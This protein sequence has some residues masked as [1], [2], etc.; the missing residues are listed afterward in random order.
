M[1]RSPPPRTPPRPPDCWERPGARNLAY[2]GAVPGDGW[3][4]LLPGRV[5]SLPCRGRWPLR[6]PRRPRAA[7]GSG[8]PGESGRDAGTYDHL[9]CVHRGRP[10]R[11]LRPR[12]APRRQIL[13]E[14]DATR[15]LEFLVPTAM[16]RSTPGSTTP[17]CSCCRFTNLCCNG[18]SARPQPVPRVGQRRDAGTKGRVMECPSQRIGRR[19]A[20]PYSVNVPIVRPLPAE[21]RSP[22]PVKLP[23]NT[24]CCP[25]YVIVTT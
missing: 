2:P 19:L 1:V 16:C 25:P 8:V 5:L 12:A 17:G 3:A 24:C 14:R 23:S 21:P 4:Q 9:P 6:A 7:S 18:P 13:C 11:N 10:R 22:G 20:P 15:A